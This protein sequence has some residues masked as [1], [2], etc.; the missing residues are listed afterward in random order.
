MSHAFTRRLPHLAAA[1]FA[2]ALSGASQAQSTF[3]FHDEKLAQVAASEHIVRHDMSALYTNPRLKINRQ[4]R[5]SQ[6][7][8]PLWD[9]ASLG[10][11]LAGLNPKILLNASGMSDS[12]TQDRPKVG[13]AVS[14]MA[15]GVSGRNNLLP[16][17]QVSGNT[18]SISEL[19]KGWRV[20]EYVTYPNKPTPL[21]GADVTFALRTFTQ[22]A[23]GTGVQAGVWKSTTG[24]TVAVRLMD[25]DCNYLMCRFVHYAGALAGHTEVR[26]GQNLIYKAFFPEI[27]PGTTLWWMCTS[28]GPQGAPSIDLATPEG[29]NCRSVATADEWISASKMMGPWQKQGK[30]DYT[31]EA[32]LTRSSAG[33]W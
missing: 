9:L 18:K 17:D 6:K 4:A 25:V 27:Q 26:F 33:T 2:A 5:S 14:V 24:S 8:P 1:L 29:R 21:K 20:Q 10:G 32:D 12:Q 31:V 16:D 22:S 23:R 19:R 15:N 28:G 11:V 30:V 3:L 13:L 7:T